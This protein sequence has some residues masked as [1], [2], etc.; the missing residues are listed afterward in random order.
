MKKPIDET[1]IVNDVIGGL[2]RAL[3]IFRRHGIDSCC[4]GGLTV[5]EAAKR[6]GIDP[7]RLVSELRKEAQ[8]TEAAA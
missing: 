3:A 2:P 1:S 6:A 8:A 7:Y 4:G 5:S